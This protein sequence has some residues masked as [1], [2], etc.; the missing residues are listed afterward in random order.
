ML[1][2]KNSE[3]AFDTELIN[4]MLPVDKYVGG[5][6]HAC[7]HLLICKIYYKSLKRYGI[8]KL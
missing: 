7:M 8:F 1:D 2:N 4:K 6:E 3:K 5:P